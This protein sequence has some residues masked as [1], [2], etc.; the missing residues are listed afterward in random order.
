MTATNVAAA[1]WSV[2][3][4]RQSSALQ[5]SA[6]QNPLQWGRDDDNSWIC[7]ANLRQHPTVGRWRD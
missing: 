1:T 5:C 6:G 2:Y 7:V 4:V 3:S